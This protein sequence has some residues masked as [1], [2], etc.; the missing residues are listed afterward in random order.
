MSGI[1]PRIQSQWLA[2][3]TLA[4]LLTCST[5]RS[6]D[7]QV[8][9][10]YTQITVGVSD[11]GWPPLLIVRNGQLS[12]AAFD[13]LSE[14][15]GSKMQPT[16][17]V[18][19]DFA[20]L[21][22]AACAGQ[23]DVV[24][25]VQGPGGNRHCLLISDPY[26]DAD[27]V[28][29]GRLEDTGKAASNFRLAG[30]RIATEAGSYIERV[31]RGRYP[32]A[33]FI[34]V[35][36]IHDGLR[37]VLNKDTDAYITLQP[38][39][40]Y[41]L[42]KAEFHGLAVLNRYR[43]TESSVHFGFPASRRALRDYISDR[44]GQMPAETRSSILA[45]WM[46]AGLI[47]HDKAEPFFLT[48][49]ERDWLRSLP[50]LRVS[51]DAGLAP[52]SY[53]DESGLPHGIAVDYLRYLSSTLGITFE[54]KWLGSF[55]N[56]VDALQTG[57]LDMI[58]V[59]VPRDPELH[60]MPVSRP[61]S[62]FPLVIV[63]RND[64]PAVSHLSDLKGKCVAIA[65][66]GGLR[67]LVLAAAPAAQIVL[68]AGIEAGIAAVAEGKADAYL[69]DLAAADY[70]LQRSNAKNLRI[71]GW[72]GTQVQTGIAMNPALA[73]R[74]MPLVNR[75]LS[76]VSESERLSIQN[77]YVSASY[78]L[79]VSWKEVLAK[80][81]P[82]VIALLGV[83]AVLWRSRRLL[84]MEADERRRTE[85]RLIDV[86]SQ[87]PLTVFQVHENPAGNFQYDW[88]SGN[89][90]EL[91][92]KR[93]SEMQGSPAEIWKSMHADDIEPLRKAIQQAVETLTPLS[94]E[95]RLL[96][97]GSY[98]WTRLRSVPRDIGT[99]QIAWSGYWADTDDEHRYAA[100]LASARDAA[101][102]ASRA[103][104]DFL[105]MMSH[106]IRTPMSGVL[107][108][109]EVL[110]HSNLSAEQGATLKL[111]DQ[112]AET[113]LQILN[114]ILDY[115]KI[116][117]GKINLE[118][119]PVDVHGICAS[120]LSLLVSGAYEKGLKVRLCIDADVAAVIAGDS[121]RIGQIL[122]NL[123]GNAIKFTAKGSVTLEVEA[124]GQEDAMQIIAWRVTDTGIGISAGDQARLFEPFVQADTSTSRRFGGTGLG[125]S[126][127]RRLVSMMNGTLQ[128]RSEPGKGTQLE[129]RLPLEIMERQYESRPL[130]GKR[131]GLQIRDTFLARSISQLLYVLGADVTALD[132]A[133]DTT[134]TPVD[135]DL[136]ID[137]RYT[138]IRP[139]E[140]YRAPAGPDDSQAVPVIYTSDVSKA[141]GYIQTGDSVFLCVNP[142]HLK[143]VRAGCLAA[144]HAE[145]KQLAEPLAS[146]LLPTTARTREEALR[147]HALVLIVED[148]AVN[149][150]LI[151]RQFELL[152]C[153][154]DVVEDGLQALEAM[155]TA[156]YGILI[157]DCHMPR[158]DGFA[159]AGHIRAWEAK[160]GRPS[161]SGRLPIIGLT[162]SVGQDGR[163]RCMAAGM[164][165][166]LFK[167]AHLKDILGCLKRRAP[168]CLPTMSAQEHDQ[169]E[170]AA[171]DPASSV[172]EQV[173]DQGCLPDLDWRLINQK[174][175]GSGRDPK[176][177][178]VLV[179]TMTS[180]ANELR[181]L[182]IHPETMALRQWIH[183][184]DGAASMLTYEPLKLALESFRAVVH[185]ENIAETSEAGKRMLSQLKQIVEHLARQ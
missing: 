39:A 135:C 157:T 5:A 82:F 81:A 44:L 54:R 36:N 102:H 123:V 70:A 8:P 88:I 11:D 73:R 84:R 178:E 60:G 166:C 136:V 181:G 130:D 95:V 66:G 99:G 79:G 180:D 164:D 48:P 55:A 122:F 162:A 103:K 134:S 182:L 144:L 96:R 14:A 145:G 163:D 50:P 150:H 67:P 7:P 3:L 78:V 112:S 24:L 152:G 121:V 34:H 140:T 2:L 72:G 18:F 132:N 156:V 125:L 13:I 101:E 172:A 9:A 45:R 25:A 129:V 113:L 51:L 179:Q 94:Q 21:L 46:T 128:M 86:T 165:E 177:I 20:T 124:V 161:G 30:K 174:I 27:T 35:P 109:V 139:G 26:F 1:T 15:L 52:Y 42:S 47:Q 85:L 100:A 31:S 133:P 104:D 32:D 97:D 76:A 68:T 58:A 29:V 119:A 43:E 105:A 37:A 169:A 106:E 154:C 12:G 40:E 127:C 56:T 22:A 62:S 17:K 176:L 57:R 170:S 141:V 6:A 167:P 61:Y 120:A 53:I 115:S 148:N 155:Q 151:R 41:A 143:G 137:D 65:E 19:P 93:V 175:G 23:V 146:Q 114:D 59:A 33:V 158:M 80:A 74:L 69:D 147:D 71:I 89:T 149:R 173:T 117:A 75:A 183:R 138:S 98:R 91:F 171:Q 159:L 92:G 64:A 4:L 16:V 126:I 142:V 110:S 160:P 49:E 107:G 28:V 63:G 38:V 168:Q 116:E 111:I 90:Q 118:H 131:V 87:L 185:R 153:A 108:L 10:A 83:V 184:L 77:R